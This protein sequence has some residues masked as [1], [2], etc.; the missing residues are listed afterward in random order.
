MT[1]KGLSDKVTFEKRPEGERR[2]GAGRSLRE[3][4]SFQGN[5]STSIKA[6]RLQCVD[7]VLGM[8]RRPLWLEQGLRTGGMKGQLADN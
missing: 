2:G 7:C 8:T 6:L 5:G 4:Q 3:E 1:R